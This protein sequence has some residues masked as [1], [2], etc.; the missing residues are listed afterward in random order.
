M[1]SAFG[2]GGLI[3]NLVIIFVVLLVLYRI[4][5]LAVNRSEIKEDITKLRAE[6]KNLHTKINNLEKSD[7]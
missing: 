5:K 2:F 6:V 7:L 1:G 4:V 3:A